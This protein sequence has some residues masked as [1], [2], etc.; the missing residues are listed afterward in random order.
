[1]SKLK[2][3]EFAK[4]GEDSTHSEES[5]IKRFLGVSD[6][7]K[8]KFKIIGNEIKQDA[9]G[10][11]IDRREGQD[12]IVNGGKELYNK[13]ISIGMNEKDWTT[14]HEKKKDLYDQVCTMQHGSSDLC[15]KKFIVLLTSMLYERGGSPWSYSNTFNKNMTALTEVMKIINVLA[16]NTLVAWD[17]AQQKFA[18]ELAPHHRERA[19]GSGTAGGKDEHADQ[20][21]VQRELANWEKKAEG[22]G[23]GSFRTRP[24]RGGGYYPD[25]AY[26]QWMQSGGPNIFLLLNALYNL[27][28]MGFRTSGLFQVESSDDYFA[29]FNKR[30]GG[31][32][33]E[34][35]ITAYPE[36]KKWVEV[37]I[38]IV[39]SNREIFDSGNIAER[40]ALSGLGPYK[41]F[42][43]TSAKV[44]NVE[45]V[46]QGSPFDMWAASGLN[47]MRYVFDNYGYNPIPQYNAPISMQLMG[48]GNNN[49]IG[50]FTF[51][52]IVSSVKG[53]ANSSEF[54]GGFMSKRT[55]NYEGALLVNKLSSY[56]QNIKTALASQ[57]KKLDDQSDNFMKSLLND[58]TIMISTIEEQLRNL[59]AWV[60]TQGDQKVS[61]GS[62]Q[63]LSLE[64]I[65]DQYSTKMRE[66]RSKMNEWGSNAHQIQ[67]LINGKEV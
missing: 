18:A 32:P 42:M 56:Y 51:E 5:L 27:N 36:F 15:S 57:N 16:H 22:A 63:E 21:D 29:E 65:L 10:K 6:T 13:D 7:G 44:Y 58:V 55:N 8:R 4:T 47:T 49:K 11:W 39:N 26:K 14:I 9:T 28:V 23:G 33:N 1:M 67:I 34:F 48:G 52:D 38:D 43:D 30:M 31:L 50:R 46:G 12:K 2:S 45:W 20:G 64:R 41:T 53:T 3:I 66:M 54:I 25:D 19:A 59:S 17:K 60:S 40:E 37:I 61:S 35:K 62:P 24:I